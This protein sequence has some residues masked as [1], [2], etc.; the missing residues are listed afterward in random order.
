MGL[1]FTTF[2]E[3]P[4]HL[5]KALNRSNAHWRVGSHPSE[6]HIWSENF[7]APLTDE[8]KFEIKYFIENN[9]DIM[10]SFLN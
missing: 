4:E 8:E 5:A 10:V 1:K 7:C 6:R 2:E 3:F 9:S